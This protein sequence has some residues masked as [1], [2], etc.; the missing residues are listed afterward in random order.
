MAQAANNMKLAKS[1]VSGAGVAGALGHIWKPRIQAKPVRLK[2]AE[3][4][5][6]FHNMMILLDA[7]LSLTQTLRTLAEEETLRRHRPLLMSLSRDIESGNSFSSSLAKFPASFSNMIVQ[8]IT[9]AE[10]TGDLGKSLK[11]IAK[12]VE[13]GNDLRKKIIRKLSY[14][15]VL[16]LA[17]GA[18]STF[19][20]VFVVP[21]YEETYAESGA[22]LP[23][24]TKVMLVLGHLLSQYGW[25]LPIL[26]VA[27]FVGLKL[28]RKHHDLSLAFDRWLLRLPVIGKLLR[29]VAAFEFVNVFGNLLDSGFTVG[30][31][32]RVAG[33]ATRNLAVRQRIM[34]IHTAVISGGRLSTEVKKHAELFP[35]MVR[36]LMSV[37]EKQGDLRMAIGH[38]RDHLRK[39]IERTTA[40]MVGTIEPV[41]T[42][43]LATVIGGIVLAI[44]LPMFDLISSTG[45]GH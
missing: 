29:N 15:A 2:P 41:A 28:V 37:G 26:P 19:M 36:Q 32:L 42:I 38:M 22:E 16:I 11:E 4:A 39:E 14:P 3:L 43:G 25:A 21:Q 40:A 20:L 6:L 8:Q 35:A 13:E 23:G 45:S 31:S 44:Y 10:R 30:E 5:A 17:G 7:G 33:Q 34:M 1:A 27:L 12:Q 18:V 9:V 24:I